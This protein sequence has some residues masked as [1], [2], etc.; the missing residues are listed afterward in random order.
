MVIIDGGDALT[1]LTEPGVEVMRDIYRGALYVLKTKLTE[2]YEKR[3]TRTTS[4]L[5]LVSKG[6]RD[7]ITW[8]GDVD[9]T[10]RRVR[11]YNVGRQR[12]MGEFFKRGNAEDK[13]EARVQAY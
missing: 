12:T 4:V 6:F 10:T 3:W 9:P 7:S 5:R 8:F 1:Y 2:A 11:A 13:T